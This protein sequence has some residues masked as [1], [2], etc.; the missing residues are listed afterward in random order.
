VLSAVRWK[1]VQYDWGGTNRIKLEHANMPRPHNCWNFV[2]LQPLSS[3]G[4]P[5]QPLPDCQWCHRHNAVRLPYT[6]GTPR[7]GQPCVG[8]CLG[9]PLVGL[10]QWI[11]KLPVTSTP[12]NHAG[13]PPINGALTRDGNSNSVLIRTPDNC[14]ILGVSY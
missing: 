1:L 13:S 5:R 10:S 8:S 3:R 7:F 6:V 9:S 4:N 14:Q 2:G 12:V 11:Y